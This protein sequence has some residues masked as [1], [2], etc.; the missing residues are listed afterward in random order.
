MCKK[1]HNLLLSS[2]FPSS[3]SLLPS[4]PLLRH[5]STNNTTS[6]IP[7]KKIQAL[8]SKFKK[9]TLIEHSTMANVFAK[10]SWLKIAIMIEHLALLKQDKINTETNL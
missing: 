4:S 10:S 8:I 9:E 1:E 6:I 2:I 3:L 7:K 5:L